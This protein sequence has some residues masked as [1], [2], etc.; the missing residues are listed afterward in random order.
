MSDV[1]DENIP[2]T[3]QQFEDVLPTIVFDERQV[4]SCNQSSH[5]NS[6]YDQN[7][8]IIIQTHYSTFIRLLKNLY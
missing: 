3:T 6:H 4:V 2:I 8:D 1:F 5:N 7:N